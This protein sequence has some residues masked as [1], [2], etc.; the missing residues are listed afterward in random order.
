MRWIAS[1]GE[2]HFWRRVNQHSLDFHEK[3]THVSVDPSCSTA[4][5][6]KTVEAEILPKA[7]VRGD[8]L[9]PRK[10]E[11][12]TSAFATRILCPN[13]SYAAKMRKYIRC[14]GRVY[15]P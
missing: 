5:V 1:E 6:T 14:S 13:I 10:Y 2:V 8:T 11:K 3:P 12:H 7:S 9:P 15:L 4:T